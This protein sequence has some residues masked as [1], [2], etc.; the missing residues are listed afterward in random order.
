MYIDGNT[1]RQIAEYLNAKKIKTPSRYMK[2]TNVARKWK[3]EQVCDIL[4]NPFYIGNTI[5][6]KYE[7]NYMKKTCQK[8]K[9][10]DTWIIEV[11]F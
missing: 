2:L 1:G 6:N 4:S 8:N 5:M 7:T 3:S 9:N 11:S 10:R